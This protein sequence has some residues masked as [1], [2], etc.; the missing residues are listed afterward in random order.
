MAQ[1]VYGEIAEEA[2]KLIDNIKELREKAHKLTVD[3]KARGDAAS[4]DALK[5]E[6]KKNM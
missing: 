1:T 3:L 2:K 4:A 5:E 6:L